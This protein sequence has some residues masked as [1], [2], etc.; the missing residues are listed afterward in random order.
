MAELH[1]PTTDARD[2]TQEGDH[3]GE[4]V[5]GATVDWRSDLQEGVRDA[6]M[7][8]AGRYDGWEF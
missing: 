5:G 8:E 4:M 1:R 3:G 2:A 6:E 7:P